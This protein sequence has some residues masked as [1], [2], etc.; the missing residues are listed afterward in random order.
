[1]GMRYKLSQ[2]MNRMWPVT[3]SWPNHLCN[4]A[5]GAGFWVPMFVMSDDSW[6]SSAIAQVEFFKILL[7][8]T[9]SILTSWS[10]FRMAYIYF[11]R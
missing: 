6:M 5:Q 9:Y 7:D 11:F 10:L 4:K 3:V 1:M 8:I 2:E